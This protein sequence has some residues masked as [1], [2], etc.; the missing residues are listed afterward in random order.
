M[1]IAGTAGQG[2]GNIMECA[3]CH[4]RAFDRQDLVNAFQAKLLRERSDRMREAA[5]KIEAL[6]IPPRT[7]G[8]GESRCADCSAP[9]VLT[10]RMVCTQCPYERR[11]YFHE[12]HAPACARC[13]DSHSM[14]HHGLEREVP[15]T[16][17]PVPC[18]ECRGSRYNSAYCRERPCPCKC[19]AVVTVSGVPKEADLGD[20]SPGRLEPYD[21]AVPAVT[22]GLFE[23]TG[24]KDAVTR[25]EEPIKPN[26]EAAA[27]GRA[28][29]HY[30]GCWREHLACATGRLDAIL[31]LAE[32]LETKAQIWS[33]RERLN[34]DG[35]PERAAGRSDAY[36]SAAESLRS[37]VDVADEEDKS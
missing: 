37:I 33:E 12:R 19:H 26:P 35:N 4:E 31:G 24:K 5:D 20:R 3:R 2:Q 18:S 7:A 21:P 10:E 25:I 17:C 8:V 36:E 23:K 6:S 15:C 16:A 30:P 34:S 27:A 13:Q 14:F 29:A 9:L 28:A 1:A 22:T 32:R 11:A